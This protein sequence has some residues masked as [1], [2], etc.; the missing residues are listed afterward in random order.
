[1]SLRGS[2]VP[3]GNL[4]R[5][6]VPFSLERRD[7]YQRY[8]EVSSYID[9]HTPFRPSAPNGSMVPGG[10][11]L[12]KSNI[13]SKASCCQHSTSSNELPKPHYL[14]S[15]WN[16]P[17]NQPRWDTSRLSQTGFEKSVLKTLNYNIDKSNPDP[18]YRFNGFYKSR[19]VNTGMH[20]K[21]TNNPIFVDPSAPVLAPR[22]RDQYQY[23]KLNSNHANLSG[24][25]GM[26]F[27]TV[28]TNSLSGSGAL[29]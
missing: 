22:K 12:R 3:G 11:H 27:G 19:F 10:A 5:S 16:E 7:L 1:M 21:I 6:S 25:D 14:P 4:N 18:D 20:A 9:T 29:H 8:G 17:W 2:S 23:G 28:D 24:S 15:L 26:R 13:T